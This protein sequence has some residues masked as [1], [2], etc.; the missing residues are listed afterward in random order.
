MEYHNSKKPAIAGNVFE[1]G[2]KTFTNLD[3]KRSEEDA[4][5]YTEHYLDFLIGLTD[6]KSMSFRF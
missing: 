3:K 6:E 1:L 5:V 4:V 2:L